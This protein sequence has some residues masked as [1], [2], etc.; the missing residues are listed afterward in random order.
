MLMLNSASIYLFS[1]SLG[2]DLSFVFFFYL[3]HALCHFLL[4]S[5]RPD[6]LFFSVFSR[7]CTLSLSGVSDNR[8]D[9]LTASLFSNVLSQYKSAHLDRLT[10]YS[11][12]S[13]SLIAQKDAT[14]EIE[15]EKTV[16]L[17][18]VL[19][20]LWS[21]ENGFGFL[22]PWIRPAYTFRI[23]FLLSFFFMSCSQRETH[24]HIKQKSNNVVTGKHGFV[25]LSN[26]D[27]L[28]S[29]SI[30]YVRCALTDADVGQREAVAG[31]YL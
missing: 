7:F 20:P 23:F 30:I 16:H 5:Q 13:G 31:C 29:L 9:P 17:I 2:L 4:L 19:V 15:V 12:L 1:L 22:Y 6:Y 24:L 26:I 21:C 28:I 11:S 3:S 27:C 8:A 18:Y 14:R 25:F 10:N